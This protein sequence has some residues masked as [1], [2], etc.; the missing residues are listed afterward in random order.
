MRSSLKVLATVATVSTLVVAGGASPAV[1][2]P[3][4]L[5]TAQQVT[6]SY[7]SWNPGTPWQQDMAKNFE[8][9]NPNIK[10]NTTYDTYSN[11]L[12]ALKADQNAG[13]LPSVMG[14]QVGGMLGEYTPDLI[15]LNVYA[16]RTWGPKWQ[17]RFLSTALNQVQVANPKGNNNFYG[18]PES[19]GSEFLTVN[20]ALFNKFKLSPPKT[21]AQM[22]AD[23]KIFNAH[24]IAELE[25]G[26]ASG[27]QNEDLF[28]EIANQV[29]PGQWYA[30][31]SGKGSF[32]TPGLAKALTIFKDLY[33]DKIVE[34]G[35]AG[36]HFYSGTGITDWNDG[37]A[38]M[39]A[40]G[41]WEIGAMTPK[42]A[43][44]DKTPVG[45]YLSAIQFPQIAPGD[46][47]R[48]L[49]GVDVA[50]G[51]SKDT[52][53]AQRSAAWK[54]IV[55]LTQ[56]PGENFYVDHLIDLPAKTPFDAKAALAG[57]YPAAK[58]YFN[59][60]LKMASEGTLR[61]VTSA[62]LNTALITELGDVS[63][64]SAS[65]ATALAALAKAARS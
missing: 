48:P 13:T 14:L 53:P 42:A 3:R 61:Y 60:A 63:V 64:G 7:V 50:L 41:S 5:S 30:A 21:F 55:Y 47:P 17:S 9:L 23:A 56:G 35:A 24:G 58:P 65:P 10:I 38:A 6:I 37:K 43:G 19:V 15:P 12:I 36:A 28:E 59:F 11:Y 51:I 40:L 33:A 4:K 29:A 2:S 16:Q 49:A 18:L 39:A 57:T 54:F 44:G 32:T 34:P 22:V 62:K 45:P 25:V 8:K 27:W 1:A 31:E 26:G 46:K 20:M 52:T